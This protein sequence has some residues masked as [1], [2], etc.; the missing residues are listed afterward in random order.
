MIVYSIMSDAGKTMCGL[1]C[2]FR[3]VYTTRSVGE[4]V[5]STSKA[6]V[7]EDCKGSAYFAG[8][9]NCGGYVKYVVWKVHFVVVAQ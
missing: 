3:K 2:T 9:H 4:K 1:C 8:Y 5:A 6:L 7:M